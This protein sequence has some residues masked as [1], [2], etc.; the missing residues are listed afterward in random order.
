MKKQK[1]LKHGL[2]VLLLIVI[3]NSAVVFAVS[4]S[5]YSIDV[6]FTWVRDGDFY[7]NDNYN[8]SINIEE[9]PYTGGIM[10]DFFDDEEMLKEI[11][12]GYVDDINQS[13]IEVV[14]Y[15][16][17][18]TNVTKNEYKCIYFTM[19][20]LYGDS[21]YYSKNYVI[22]LNDRAFN[23]T[24]YSRNKEGLEN[25]ELKN[26][27]DSFTI[28]NYKPLEQKPQKMGIFGWIIIIFLIYIIIG[29]I[30]SLIENNKKQQKRAQHRKL[31]K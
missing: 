29:A 1:I 24:V 27:I 28:D 16:S 17:E 9:E 23:V 10:Y 7:E 31:S 26:I 19:T 3:I 15:N 11:C 18:I 21:N 22:P 25:T 13:G 14:S 5:R 30:G 2:I 8:L 4:L 6:P 12:E 20:L